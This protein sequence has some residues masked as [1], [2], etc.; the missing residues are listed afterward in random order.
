MTYF[1]NKYQPYLFPLL[2][3]L[4]TAGLQVLGKPLLRYQNDVISTLEFWRLFT[5][6]WVHLNW[7]HWLLNNLGFILLAALTKVNW[8]LSFWIKLILIHSLFISLMLLLL[9]PQLHWYVGFSGLLYGLYIVAAWL[10]YNKDKFISIMIMA[11]VF[12]KIGLEQLFGSEVS[13]QALLGAPVVVDAHA[14][15]LLCGIFSAVFLT[16]QIKTM[17]R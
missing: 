4:L 7:T 14:Y 6:H 5:G 9:N 15:G 10:S 2:W 11:L 8:R 13:T 16:L 3:L 12:I 17:K 1:N